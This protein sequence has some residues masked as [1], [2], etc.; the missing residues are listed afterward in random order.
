MTGT[1]VIIFIVSAVAAFAAGWLV[2][3][4]WN[5]KVEAKLRDELDKIRSL[6]R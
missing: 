3:R 2:G 4:K 5:T 6:G 1:L